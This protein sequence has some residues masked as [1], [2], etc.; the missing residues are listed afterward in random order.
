MIEIESEPNKHITRWKLNNFATSWRKKKKKDR[1]KWFKGVFLEQ[2]YH[3]PPHFNVWKRR[4]VH[5]TFKLFCV[6]F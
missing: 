4:E 1:D 3:K 5:T 6:D 2:K